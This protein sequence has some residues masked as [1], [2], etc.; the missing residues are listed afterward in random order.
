MFTVA[1]FTVTK[2]WKQCKYPSIDEWIKKMWYTHTH[3]HTHTEAYYI[4]IRKNEIGAPGWLSGLKPLTLA[5]VM[6]SG[7]WD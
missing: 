6:I 2:L 4:A 3:T 1:L 5:Q 7:S